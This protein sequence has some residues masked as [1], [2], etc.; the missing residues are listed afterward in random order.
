[1]P[2]V[3][4]GFQFA[5]FLGELGPDLGDLPVLERGVIFTEQPDPDADM[6]AVLGVGPPDQEGEQG[7]T[8][9]AGLAAT[10]GAAVEDVAVGFDRLQRFSLFRRGLEQV[11][12]DA[13]QVSSWIM[14][15]A[16]RSTCWVGIP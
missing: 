7:P 12:D 15:L 11:G 16:F 1:M 2:L 13:G 6:P 5:Q 3:L 8:E 14:S 4:G 9:K 10:A